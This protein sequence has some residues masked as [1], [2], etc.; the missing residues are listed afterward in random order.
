[1]NA[2]IDKPPCPGCGRTDWLTAIDLDVIHADANVPNCTLTP[3]AARRFVAR[4]LD[5]ADEAEQ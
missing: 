1:M 4:L 3:E 5:A 2:Y